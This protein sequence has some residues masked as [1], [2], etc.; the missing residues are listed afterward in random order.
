MLQYGPY[1]PAA[2]ALDEPKRRLRPMTQVIKNWLCYPNQED[3]DEAA[4]A[5]FL[6]NHISGGLIL[7]EMRS[8]KFDELIRDNL[9]IRNR[10]SKHP[11]P[12]VKA[13]S[14]LEDPSQNAGG[15]PR[16]EM[17]TPMETSDDLFVE[18]EPMETDQ[19]EPESEHDIA[20][21]VYPTLAP[22][23]AKILYTMSQ[24]IAENCRAVEPSRLM[25]MYDN[26]QAWGYYHLPLVRDVT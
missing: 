4:E 8:G 24:K 9:P 11:P 19:V 14:S 1:R 13:S 12:T 15:M 18:P 23:A 25:Y 22:D 6:A 20:H 3:P 16:G 17:E 5:E 10:R 7:P 2:E 26:P 21:E